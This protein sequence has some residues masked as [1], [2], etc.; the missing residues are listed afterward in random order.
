MLASYWLVY[1]CLRA[2]LQ[3]FVVAFKSDMYA[4]LVVQHNVNTHFLSLL[5]VSYVAFVMMY[6]VVFDSICND[7]ASR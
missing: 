6:F 7:R 2:T 1:F 4:L 5:C 3:F